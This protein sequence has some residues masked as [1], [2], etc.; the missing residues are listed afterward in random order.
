MSYA[1]CCFHDLNG[2]LRDVLRMAQRGG[3]H[4]AGQL[5]DA[6]P[7]NQTSAGS[8]LFIKII[9]RSVLVLWSDYRRGLDL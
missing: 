9:F 4:T 3:S 5:G 6:E 8:S 2:P 7:P 1:P